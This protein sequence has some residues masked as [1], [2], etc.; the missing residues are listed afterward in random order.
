M[1]RY[2][3]P[4]AAAGL[5]AVPAVGLAVEPDVTTENANPVTINP[6]ASNVSQATCPPGRR[7]V[8]GGFTVSGLPT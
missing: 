8:G 6:G 7:V 3:I 2:L 1:R 5:L 4:L